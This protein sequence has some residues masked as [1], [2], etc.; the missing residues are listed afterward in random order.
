MISERISMQT[1]ASKICMDKNSGHKVPIHRVEFFIK[2]EFDKVCL[3][4]LNPNLGY[5][6]N[7]NRNF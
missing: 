3:A 7:N 5:N 1:H 6:V 4:V 2:Y